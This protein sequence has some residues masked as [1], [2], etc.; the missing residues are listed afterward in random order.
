MK[1]RHWVLCIVA[2]LVLLGAAVG[3]EVRE[4][5]DDR[6]NWTVVGRR[7]VLPWQPAPEV[8]TF[9]E[10]DAQPAARVT[11]WYCYGLAFKHSQH[12][13]KSK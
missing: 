5:S 7:V 6:G 8:A 13:T 12:H 4:T 3:V 9:P 2:L 1:R 10:A 11:R